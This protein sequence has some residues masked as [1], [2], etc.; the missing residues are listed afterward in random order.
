VRIYS[1]AAT[2][3]R[4]KLAQDVEGFIQ[5]DIEASDTV[6]NFDSIGGGTGISTKSANDARAIAFAIL[7]AADDFANEV[8]EP[9]PVPKW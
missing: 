6:F 2:P 5:L 7:R 8:T 9:L 1:A 4:A 3:V